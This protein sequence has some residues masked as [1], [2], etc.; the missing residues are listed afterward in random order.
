MSEIPDTSTT[1][2]KDLAGDV[3]HARWVEFV[4]KYQPMLE[5]YMASHFPGL[6]AEEIIQETMI[7]IAEALPNYQYEPDEKG[8]FH[9]FLTGILKRK[10]LDEIERRERAEEREK[11]YG[12][13]VRA[14]KLSAAEKR[15]KEWQE[16]I[17]EIALQEVLADKTIY[18][19][20]KEVFV[21]VAVNGEDVMEVA[22]AYGIERNAVDQMKSRMMRKMKEVIGRLEAVANG[23]G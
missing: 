14:G 7:A 12:D 21:R 17:F 23:R 22:K 16:T 10:S 8:A 4:K 3:N 5:G 20:T 15:E 6:E 1:L 19:R 11:G 13:V 2:L 18:G 9:N